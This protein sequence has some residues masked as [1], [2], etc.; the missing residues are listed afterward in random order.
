MPACL[1]WEGIR[2][3]THQQLSPKKSFQ[4]FLSLILEKT[5][6]LRQII[7]INITNSRCDNSEKK[8]C[9]ISVAF[10]LGITNWT[11][12]WENSKTQNEN[13]SLRLKKIFYSI[14]QTH[15]YYERQRKA[16]ELFQMKETKETIKCNTST[17]TSSGG[18]HKCCQGHYEVSW[19]LDSEW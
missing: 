18:K 9:I 19:Q 5:Q 15:H 12:S 10:W 13:C 14:L 3:H 16:Q 8:K 2:V 11:E 4:N 17:A 1:R 7:K 6:H